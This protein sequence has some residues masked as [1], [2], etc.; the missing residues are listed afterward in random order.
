M[1]YLNFIGN[2]MSMLVSN[3]PMSEM[4]RHMIDVICHS[5][6]VKPE[7][8]TKFSNDNGKIKKTVIF[9]KWR[10]RPI[11]W[12]VLDTQADKNLLL[13]RYALYLCPFHGIEA[14]TANNNPF[15]VRNLSATWKNSDIRFE[16][17]H[18]FLQDCFNDKERSLILKG[19]AITQDNPK[20]FTNGCQNVED[21]VFLLSSE[22][23]LYYLQDNMIR[24][25]DS[26]FHDYHPANPWDAKKPK[27][28]PFCWLRSPG[29]KDGYMT[30]INSVEPTD[31][32]F[33]EIS[34]EGADAT[35]RGLIRPAMWISKII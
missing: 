24:K 4:D 2:F 26:I 31:S 14:E 34:L 25:T 30:Y 10:E 7:L 20:Y 27:N 13:S 12:W 28:I 16:L 29:E 22:E 9:G 15:R 19:C 21:Y 23:A 35:T 5:A 33:K 3:D 6:L 8:A 18:S 17:N 11:E 1:C 32:V